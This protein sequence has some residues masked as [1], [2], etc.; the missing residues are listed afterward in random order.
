MAT[1]ASNGV[2]MKSIVSFSGGIDS[3]YVLWKELTETSNDVLA[4]YF[5]AP[6][7]ADHL[8]ERK[9]IRALTPFRPAYEIAKR[10][11]NYVKLIQSHTRPFDT[12]IVYYDMTKLVDP[13]TGSNNSAVLRVKWA[14][15]RINRG[16]ADRF[17]SGHCRDNDAYSE[18][19]GAS[20]DGQTGSNLSMH[21]FRQI[22]TRGEY[23]MPL[24]DSNYSVAHAFAELPQEI[25]D[26]NLS[27]EDP[28]TE[29]NCGYC[30]GCSYHKLAKDKLAS[31]MTP[32]QFFNFVM[33]KSVLPNGFWDSPKRWLCEEIPNYGGRPDMKPWPMPQWPNS[34]KVPE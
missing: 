30:Y 2:M 28:R 24:I 33:N 25:I 1:T 29:N 18:G 7:M 13:K 3:T 6:N 23:L 17:I 26:A 20:I 22:A 4:V 9:E 12:S 19:N 32:D 21:V 11:P 14:V 5:V 31:G 8:S 16:I 34:Y 27:C 15:D 10:I